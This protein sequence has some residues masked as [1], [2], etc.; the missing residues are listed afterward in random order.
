MIQKPPPDIEDIRIR[1]TSA[2]RANSVATFIWVDT[3]IVIYQFTCYPRCRMQLNYT[4]KTLIFN[5]ECAWNCDENKINVSGC[6]SCFYFCMKDMT[7]GS[8]AFEHYIWINVRLSTASP[9]VH[10]C[11]ILLSAFITVFLQMDLK[12]KCDYPNGVLLWF[13]FLWGST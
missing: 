4:F 8:P 1:F 9:N 11:R 2:S 7:F 13:L 12:Q 10:Q 3:N 6:F 5:W